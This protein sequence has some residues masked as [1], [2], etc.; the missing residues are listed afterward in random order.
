VRGASLFLVAAM[1]ALAGPA[2]S[3]AF[4]GLDSRAPI[5]LNADRILVQEHANR[6]ILSGNVHVQQGDMTLTA[7]QIVVA[8][9]GGGVGSV[10]RM[11]ATGG[12]TVK[13]GN[14]SARG[15]YAT[16]EPN[17]RLISLA[18][19]IVLNQGGNTMRGGRLLIDLN[20]GR[21]VVD[22]RG[23]AAPQDPATPGSPSSSNGRVS[24]RFSVSGK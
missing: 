13:R 4:R 10:S 2:A 15:S 23:G 6:A 21:A 3:Q 16:Y 22:G 1:V 7:A 8:Y 20:S 24:G 14:E 11:D 18:G 12:V 9:T 17:R 5:N 19:G